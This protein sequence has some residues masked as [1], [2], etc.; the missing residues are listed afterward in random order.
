MGSIDYFLMGTRFSCPEWRDRR[1]IHPQAK[2]SGVPPGDRYGQPSAAKGTRQPRTTRRGYCRI[3]AQRAG[4]P[5]LKQSA[6]IYGAGLSFTTNSVLIWKD[7]KGIGK[8]GRKG[9]LPPRKGNRLRRRGPG[10]RA[11]RGGDTVE[12]RPRGPGHPTA[13]DCVLFALDRRAEAV[14]SPHIYGAGLDFTTNSVLIWKDAK[15]NW[16]ERQEGIPAAA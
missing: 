3:P 10:N 15:D 2:S 13:G 11:Q 5:D 16:Q 12:S 8:S 9:F 14:N 1:T 6:H 4:A 7:A